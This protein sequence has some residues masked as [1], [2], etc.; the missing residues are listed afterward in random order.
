M[1]ADDSRRKSPK[2]G[3]RHFDDSPEQDKPERVSSKSRSSKSRSPAPL[4]KSKK[5]DEEG[6]DDS[7]VDFDWEGYD[8]S[9]ED[10]ENLFVGDRRFEL[11]KVNMAAFWTLTVLSI[12][13]ANA[14]GVRTVL[15]PVNEF[16]TMV[17]E[18]CH[19]VVALMTGGQPSLTIVDDG[20]GHAG[21]TQFNG[22]FL[23]L[24]AQAGYL[25]TAFFGCFL[26]FLGQFHKYSRYI[27]MAIGT[28]IILSSLIFITPS[29]FSFT[30]WWSGL[31]SMAWGLAMG[32]TLIIMSLKL[33]PVWANLVLLF[34]AVQT[35]LSSITLV[36]FLLPHS[37]GLAG[38]GFSDATVMQQYFLIPAPFWAV[39]WI[40]MSIGMLLLTIRFT[41][42]RAVISRIKI[43][44]SAHAD[45][46]S[47][48]DFDE[49]EE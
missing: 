23:F 41:Y 1:T 30:T 14:P 21:L 25:G 6:Y 28:M 38:K 31:L 18:T 13:L 15:T 11:G 48:K 2:R 3:A 5:Y 44:K 45:E 8:D 12:L 26:I 29:I 40:L 4:F 39:S 24:S 16:V 17:H 34:L 46:E 22:G 35:A 47:E 49:D 43:R 42:G 7:D 32:V 33:K 19:A 27:L 37:L 20:M 10:V 9:D 36:W